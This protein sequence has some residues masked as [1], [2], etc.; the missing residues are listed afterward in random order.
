MYCGSRRG[1]Y[2][3]TYKYVS[4]KMR[5][6]KMQDNKLSITDDIE[7]IFEKEINKYGTGAKIDAPKNLMGRKVYVLVRRE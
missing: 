7:F 2:L 1:K 4:L 6:I 5:K 3:Y